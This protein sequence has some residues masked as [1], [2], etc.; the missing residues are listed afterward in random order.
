MIMASDVIYKQPAGASSIGGCPRFLA[1][2]RL[3]Y[4]MEPPPAHMQRIF[5]NANEQEGEAL[6]WLVDTAGGAAYDHQKE[7]AWDLTLAMG[8]VS[9]VGHIDALWHPSDPAS[10]NPYL[11]E[12]KAM[13]R[14]RFEMV[15]RD[16]DGPLALGGIASFEGYQQQL[17]CY[18]RGFAAE[19]LGGVIV[20]AKLWQQDEYILLNLNQLLI[21]TLVEKWKPIIR[22]K[23]ALVEEAVATGDI[24]DVEDPGEWGCKQCGAR[25]HC[26]PE[27]LEEERAKAADFS[28]DYSSDDLTMFA[29]ATR[30]R[31][32]KQKAKE[33]GEEAREHFDLRL[34]SLNTRKLI[35][36]SDGN[37]QRVESKRTSLDK[38]ALVQRVGQAVVDECTTETVSE[39]IRFYPK[40]EED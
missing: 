34:A 36:A 5:D 1:Y 7:V 40:A 2:A 25:Y 29:K 8:R 3:G 33:L 35:I 23:L 39:G 11:V 12:V 32:L 9:I 21:S 14:D 18:W 10:P 26:H 15:R 16:R 20:I 38:K 28:S 4:D 17:V 22:D 24:P 30:A 19:E 31:S 37:V 27:W 6:E 13:S